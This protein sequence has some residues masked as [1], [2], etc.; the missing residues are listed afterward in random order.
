V[1]LGVWRTDPELSAW[2][3]RSR[4]NLGVT[5]QMRDDPV[6]RASID[7]LRRYAGPA[8]ERVRLC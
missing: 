2:I 1:K 3:H 5:E 8:I 4:L 7:R 6:V